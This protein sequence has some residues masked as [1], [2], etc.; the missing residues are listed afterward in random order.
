MAYTKDRRDL[1]LG[2]YVIIIRDESILVLALNDMGNSN[3]YFLKDP[4]EYNNE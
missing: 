1:Y 3:K 4:M 2:F